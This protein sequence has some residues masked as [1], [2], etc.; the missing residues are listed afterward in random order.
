MLGQ[1]LKRQKPM[2]QLDDGIQTVK[3]Q[4][5]VKQ[6]KNY[7]PDASPCSRGI[8]EKEYSLQQK[9]AMDDRQLIGYL[10]KSPSEGLQYAISLYGGGV[11]T[12]CSN[13]LGFQNSRDIDECVSDV[14]VKLWKYIGQFRPEKDSSL[15]SYLFGIARYTAID[16]RRKIGKTSDLLPIEENDIECEV[17]FEQETSKKINQQLVRE[18]IAE[19]PPPD[20]EIFIYRYF[21]YYKVE[22]IAMKL[23]LNFKTVENKLFRGKSKLRNRL[24][25][26]GVIL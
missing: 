24:I 8:E 25:E 16:R 23:G 4:A 26:K 7:Q 2:D 13:I 19:L 10:K 22:D 3:R 14:F 21:C 15:K 9:T 18:V 1:V 11:K 12:I 20:K 17:D 5:E 6:L